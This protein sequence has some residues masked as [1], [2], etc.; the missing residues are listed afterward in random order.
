MSRLDCASNP[1]WSKH[2]NDA[3]DGKKQEDRSHTVDQ[4]TVGNGRKK[5]LAGSVC[6]GD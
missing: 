2:L 5:L 1:L 4:A 3:D 6:D